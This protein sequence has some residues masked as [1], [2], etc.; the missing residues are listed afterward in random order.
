MCVVYK[1]ISTSKY[2]EALGLRS[3]PII[4][5]LGITPSHPMITDRTQFT[6]LHLWC[7]RFVITHHQHALWVLDPSCN[8][9]VA[10]L[11]EHIPIIDITCCKDSVY[12]LR[13]TKCP[14]VKLSLHADFKRDSSPG[15]GLC[16]SNTGSDVS[17]A[18]DSGSFQMNADLTSDHVSKTRAG[19]LP[20][21]TSTTAISSKEVPLSSEQNLSQD[22]TTHKMMSQDSPDAG[23][24]TNQNVAGLTLAEMSIEDRLHKMHFPSLDVESSSIAVQSVLKKKKKKKK[25]PTSHDAA[26]KLII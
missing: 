16:S 26:S 6:L 24:V 7:G 19:S 25:K 23:H 2:R 11:A 8:S 12:L 18:I 15:K 17:S 22:V 10:T 5:L 9:V 1:V 14:I 3:I 13:P 21:G 4:P 20:I